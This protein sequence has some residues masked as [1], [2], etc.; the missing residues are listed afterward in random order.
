MATIAHSP[1]VLR[2]VDLL[3]GSDDYKL[4]TSQVEFTPATSPVTWT[5][6]GNNSFS[7]TPTATW[8]VTMA[9]AQ[10]WTTEN[11]LS[12][13]LLENEGD[14]VEIEF[15]PQSGG[16]SFT[17]TVTITPGGIGGTAGAVAVSSVTMSCSKP[18]YVPVV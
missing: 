13:F 2:D 3:I 17:S 12:R 8:T 5:G 4:H 14:E 9:L 10:D 6:L 16:P 7:A 18:V 15:A 1:F 11:S